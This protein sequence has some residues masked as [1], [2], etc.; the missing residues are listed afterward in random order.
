MILF[1]MKCNNSNCSRNNSYNSAKSIAVCSPPLEIENKCLAEN[2][3]LC[4]ELEKNISG[5]C[6]AYKEISDEAIV[7]QVHALKGSNFESEKNE[8]GTAAIPKSACILKVPNGRVMCFIKGLSKAYL[9]RRLNLIR[10]WKDR[11]LLK[12]KHHK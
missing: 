3:N 7:T 4:S 8:H 9:N 5:S 11:F 10:R 6:T 1:V 12:N 2:L